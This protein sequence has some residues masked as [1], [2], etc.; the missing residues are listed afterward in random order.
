[1]MMVMMMMMMMRSVK[2]PKEAVV[3]DG[4]DG[5]R[6]YWRAGRGG[7]GPQGCTVGQQKIMASTACM[8]D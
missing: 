5:M 7:S 1:M 4:D 2:W 6:D 3:R 8:S